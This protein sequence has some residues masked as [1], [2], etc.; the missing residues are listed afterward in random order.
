MYLAVL[1]R[2][3]IGF[4]NSP[5]IS[6]VIFL[7]LI[8]GLVFLG[9][10]LLVRNNRWIS[11]SFASLELLIILL[12]LLV[13]HSIRSDLFA[14]LF[15]V[16]AMQVMR[17]HTPQVTAIVLGLSTIMTFFTLFQPF[18]VLQ[19]LALS[20][21]YN[22]LGMFIAVYIWTTRQARN[23]QE[24]QLE[25]A[26][27]LQQANRT[28]DHYAH[29]VHQLATGRERQRLARELHD[30]VTQTIFSMTL[31]VQT[32]RKAMKRDRTR[33]AEQLDRLDYL[34]HGALSEMQTLVSELTPDGRPRD[35]IEELKQHLMERERLDSLS[36]D[37]Q[38]KGNQTL[39]AAEESCLYRITQEALN[40]IV[41]HAR[42]KTA[43]LYLHLSQPLYMEI[44]DRG[45]GFDPDEIN[46]GGRMG[47]KGMSERAADI[48]WNFKVKSTPGQGCLI[49][50]EK[51]SLRK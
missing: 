9:N 2:S 50:V 42:I 23:I 24:R 26:T 6:I 39:T 33:V 37:L 18:G 17:R 16:T 35:F 36:V 5:R 32:A 22:S 1:L 11:I 30:S 43:N 34:A 29:E 21:V 28:L 48:G 40:N 20:L 19:A 13:T 46:G 4:Q 12:L 14:F 51:G 3:I 15:A 44:E 45:I 10:E 47:L 41:K 8:W 25:L 31:A 49:R 27:E 38:V 7:V